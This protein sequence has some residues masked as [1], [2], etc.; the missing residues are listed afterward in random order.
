VKGYAQHESKIFEEV[1]RLRTQWAGAKGPE[2]RIQA[3]SQLDGVM[4]RLMMVAESYP[5]LKADANF[6]ALQD[7][8][9][10]TENRINVERQ[11]YNDTI[12]DYNTTVRSF[13]GVVFAKI[14]GFAPR[15]GYF[16]AEAGADKAPT[17]SF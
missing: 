4:G 9:T 12:R 16:K 15:T 11:R 6:R 10:G 8:L 17:V 2:A 14:G 5:Q 7:E 13:P 3:A 1:A